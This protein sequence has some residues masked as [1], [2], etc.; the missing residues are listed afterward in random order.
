MTIRPYGITTDTRGNT[1][2]VDLPP[3]GHTVRLKSGGPDM[4][5][6]DT[7]PECGD[8]DVAYSDGVGL[9]FETLPAA[10]L[11]SVH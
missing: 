9:I 1:V 6:L 5:V 7:C 2:R 10:C 8:V 4:T 11:V 3:V